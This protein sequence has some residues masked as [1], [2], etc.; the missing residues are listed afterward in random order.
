MQQKFF[1]TAVLT[2]AMALMLPCIPCFAEETV[3]KPILEYD[4]M[5]M[6]TVNDSYITFGYV[7]GGGVIITECQKELKGDLV[8]PEVLDNEA[9]IGIGEGAFYEV[10][11][12]TSV[13]MPETV[14]E[15][16]AGAFY[17]C[18]ALQSVNLPKGLTSIGESAFY[19][20]VSFK[21]A[22]IPDGITTITDSC[23]AQCYS[24]EKLTLPAKLEK[25]EAEAFYASGQNIDTLLLPDTLTEMGELAFYGWTRIETVDIP[26]GLQTLGD[27]VF[28]GCEALREI[29]VEQDNP[30]Y[31]AVDGVLHDKTC[32]RLIKYP[33][34]K[35]GENYTLK[36][37]VTA[38]DGWAF[39]GATR[40]QSIDLNNAVTLGEETFYGCSALET[41]TLNDATAELPSAAFTLCSALKEITIPASCTTIGTHCFT[42]CSSLREVTVP[43]GVTQI[44][45]YAFGYDFDTETQQL[46]KLKKFRMRVLVG[47]EG[48]AYAKQY[49][50]SY[51]SNSKL[52][53]IV[54][55]SLA[56]AAIAAVVFI[57]VMRRRNIVRIAAGPDK[58]KPVAKQKFTNS[59]NGGK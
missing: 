15:I 12:L 1:R 13:T 40:L 47:T 33:P 54:G 41:V 5:G 37:S 3:G 19:Q 30:N 17:C 28:D 42:G 18:E 52:G 23:F 51:R 10:K 22:E 4:D 46:R 53:W 59:K 44:G 39:V 48:I 11:G 50:V 24:L 32:T 58:G 56:V 49:D 43:A 26:K 45:D 38:V 16:G 31:I 8:I 2:A 34:A 6:Y 35:D 55:I 21:T 27:Y 9:V 14:T 29:R 57:V 7:E 20:C 36:D 25:I